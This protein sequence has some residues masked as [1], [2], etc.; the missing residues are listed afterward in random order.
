M[1]VVFVRGDYQEQAQGRVNEIEAKL[2]VFRSRLYVAQ[3][4]NRTVGE[5]KL[6]KLRGQKLVVEN[7]LS[8][9]RTADDHDWMKRRDRFECAMGLL[10]QAASAALKQLR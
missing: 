2:N 8:E 9:L 4:R 6:T 5:R 1:T 3:R 10:E 7:R